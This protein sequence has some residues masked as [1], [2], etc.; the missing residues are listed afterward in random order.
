MKNMQK[1]N[2][3]ML[4]VGE[5]MYPQDYLGALIKT[6]REEVSKMDCNLVASH[7]LMC[8][9]DAE[10]AAEALIGKPIDLFIVN[11]VSWHITPYV[12]HVLKNYRNVP[13]LIWGIGGTTDKTGKLH[14]PAAAAGI[15]GFMPIVKEFGF[16]YKVILEKPDSEH[17]YA[18]VADYIHSISC[19]KTVRASRIGLIGYADMGL[20]TCAYDKTGLF[21]KLG[22]DIEDYSGYEIAKLMSAFPEEKVNETIELIKRETV[23]ENKIADKVLGNVARLYLAMKD[24]ADGR[25]LDAV[26]IKCVNGTTSQLGFNPCLAQTLLASRD[27]S[28]ICE[29][30][31]YGLVT[32]IILSTVTGNASAFM[33]HYEIFDKEVL[34]GVCGFIPPEFA[35]GITKVRAANLGETN[36]GISNVSK[37]KTGEV[38]FGR[39]YNEGGKF[40][41]FPLT[42]PLKTIPSG[43]SLAGQSLRPTSPRCF[44]SLRFPCRNTLKTFPAST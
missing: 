2:V 29:C 32:S 40:K 15:T 37:V 31:A 35:N 24:K 1:A 3:V 33:E 43:Q 16:K 44:L 41:F 12:M 39:F 23:F 36:T 25:H 22:I 21:T 6:L 34:V 26:S 28:V 8:M 10:N 38:T 13:L 14:S 42:E 4:N 19:A 30:D 27:L 11:F 18:A 17:E 7:T 20:Y 5:E 9:K